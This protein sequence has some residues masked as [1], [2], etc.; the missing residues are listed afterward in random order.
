MDNLS[1]IIK[2]VHVTFLNQFVR[3]NHPFE[4]CAILLGV[5]EKD[6]FVVEEIVPAQN[7]DSSIIRFTIDN[8]MLFEIYKDADEKNLSVIGIFHSHPS[9]PYPS[10]T[11]KNYMK[12]NPVPWV[13]KSTV[14][15]EMRCFIL[16]DQYN[17]NEAMIKEIEI[18]ITD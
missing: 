10:S 9:G 7:K 6:E 12:I 18:R 13:I 2:Q 16:E 15:N 17:G 8:D 14:T 4:A 1:I 11:D 5:R 3:A